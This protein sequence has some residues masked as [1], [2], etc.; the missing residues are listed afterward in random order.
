[1]KCGGCSWL[2]RGSSTLCTMWSLQRSSVACTIDFGTSQR[3]ATRLVAPTLDR[4]IAAESSHHVEDAGL[5]PMFWDHSNGTSLALSILG[6]CE[7]ASSRSPTNSGS[8]ARIDRS[9]RKDLEGFLG[10]QGECS[11]HAPSACPHQ[12]G[13]LC[14]HAPRVSIALSFALSQYH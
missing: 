2:R 1:M 13:V 3:V 8:V 12:S 9:A 10:T 11:L 14:R 5:P 7:S 4:L 6:C